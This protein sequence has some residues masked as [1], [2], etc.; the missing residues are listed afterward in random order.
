MGVVH[1]PVLVEEVMMLLRCESGRTYVDAFG[2]A[3]MPWNSEAEWTRWM[4]IG[5]D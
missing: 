3:A 4:V 5:L 1:I 2:G